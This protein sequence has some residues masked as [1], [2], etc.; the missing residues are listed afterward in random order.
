MSLFLDVLSQGFWGGFSRA[1]FLLILLCTQP[2]FAYT[3]WFEFD[4]ALEFS[5]VVAWVRIEGGELRRDINGEI[6]GAAYTA[7]VLHGIKGAQDGESFDFG[8]F[9]GRKIG[10]QYFV[11]LRTQNASDLDA[12]PNCQGAKPALRETAEGYGTIELQYGQQSGFQSAVIL[13]SPPYEIPASMPGFQVR[14]GMVD[15]E[16]FLGTLEMRAADFL[17]WL[18]SKLRGSP[19]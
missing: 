12:R 7:K 4:R 14:G 6:C 3:I 9:S 18:K 15:E 16:L 1:S 19:P 11:F 10:A 8:N 17:N 5:E 2:C 13:T